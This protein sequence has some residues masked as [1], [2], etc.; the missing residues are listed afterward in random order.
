M[1]VL[2]TGCSSSA[3][4]KHAPAMEISHW[5]PNHL[6]LNSRQYDRL[7][8]EI[9]AVEGCQPRKETVEAL[10]RFLEK[11]CHK[12]DGI[13]IV[14]DSKIK[15]AE[16]QSVKPELLAL[17]H[18]AGPPADKNDNRTAYLYILFYDSSR[19]AGKNYSGTINPYM[20]IL[21][22]P[23]AI[24]VDVSYIR[25]KCMGALQEH[26]EELLLHEAGHILGLRWAEDNSK[27]E[28]CKNKSC[29]MHELYE[30][31]MFKVITGQKIKKKHFCKS[32]IKYLENAG[33]S[34]NAD[35]NKSKNLRFI[36]PLMVRSEK[37]Y[38][39]IALPSFVKLYFGSIDSIVWQDI[40]AEA[41]IEAPMRAH[42]P[43]TVAV[44]MG[45]ENAEETGDIESVH[46]M[47]ANAEND[48]YKT[49]RLGVNM[50]KKGLW[51][52]FGLQ[53]LAKRRRQLAQLDQKEIALS[54]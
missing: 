34:E 36:G 29:L 41:R 45:T 37:D 17:E 35:N 10:R 8:V 14:N 5:K 40:L 52:Q 4:S 23:S 7:F 32:C 38:H 51:R 21:P 6:Y 39:V 24:Y 44:V 47:I 11:Y 15:T 19:L 13:E 27:D 46:K 18:M 3:A 16:I 28:H 50:I 30:V 49:V 12:P 42:K 54:D 53:Y 9:D 2:L 1:V 31:N 20:R 33:N 26:E 25:K 43:D 48:P 22:Y